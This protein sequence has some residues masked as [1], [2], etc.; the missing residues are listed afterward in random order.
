M[1]F[2]LPD[3]VAW[4]A[5][6]LTPQASPTF[7]SG[8]GPVGLFTSTR[9]VGVVVAVFTALMVLT[10][11]SGWLLALRG[12]GGWERAGVIVASLGLWDGARS[13]DLYIALLGLIAVG[14]CARALLP[15]SGPARRRS[16]APQEPTLGGVLGAPDGRFIRRRRLVAP[17]EPPE[18][19]GADGMEQRVRVQV[20]TVDE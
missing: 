7:P 11:V 1:P 3:P 10:V 18:Q 13:L 15:G 20:H 5:G 4:V 6:G 8:R 17:T 14:V 2:V 19:I 16:P 12:R 9:H